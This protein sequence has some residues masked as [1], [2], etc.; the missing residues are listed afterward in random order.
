MGRV[1]W[2]KEIIGNKYAKLIGGGDKVRRDNK[3]RGW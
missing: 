1:R 3:G 2:R